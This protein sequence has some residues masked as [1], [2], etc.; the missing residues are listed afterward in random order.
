M[1]V[2]VASRIRSEFRALGTPALS[3]D[4]TLSTF[5]AKR[6]VKLTAQGSS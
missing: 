2:L 6:C 3:H 4:I 5:A 1:H